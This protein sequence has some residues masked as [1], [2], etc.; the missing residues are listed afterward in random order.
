MTEALAMLGRSTA[1]APPPNI[2]VIAAPAASVFI[3][4]LLVLVIVSA[5][6]SFEVRPLVAVGEPSQQ[7]MDSVDRTLVLLPS[8]A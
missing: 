2:H 3:L 8:G 6:L 7:A 1:T 5:F 4:L